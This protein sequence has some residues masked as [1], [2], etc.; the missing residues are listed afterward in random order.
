MVSADNT[1]VGL[2]AAHDVD[3]G[4]GEPLLK[5]PAASSA[6]SSDRLVRCGHEPT[7][8]NLAHG[9]VRKAVTAA[10]PIGP[11]SLDWVAWPEPGMT[12]RWPRGA[13]AASC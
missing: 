5:D 9:P 7:G 10:R 12:T 3:K 6:V 2:R 8:R 13:R 4:L 11:L 1:V